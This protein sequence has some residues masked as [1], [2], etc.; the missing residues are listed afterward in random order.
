MK[1][2]L[3]FLILC[4][5]S[6]NVFAQDLPKLPKVNSLGSLNKLESLTKHPDPGAKKTKQWSFSINP[7]LWTVA[8][9]GTVGV[10]NTPSG[11]PKTFEFSKSFS[12]A[13]SSLKFAFM[14]GGRLKHKKVSFF[15][16]LSYANLKEFDI[17][18]PA[19]S[20]LTSAN[21]TNKELIID[22]SL[23]YE[24]YTGRSTFLDVYAGTR[25]WSLKSE[26]TLVPANQQPQIMLSSDKSWVDPIVGLNARFILGKKWFSY[27]RTD[28]GGFGVG[29]S[30]DFMLLG[31]FGYDLNPN[32]NTTLGVKYLG[33]DYD[34]DD[35]RWNVNHYGLLLSIGYRY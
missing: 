24:F 23:G 30:W 16:D 9:G 34:K 26:I 2:C 33:L 14:V 13:L 19:N 29:S 31:G 5:F 10:P 20:G 3:L 4:I 32:W 25:I 35:V 21:T 12:D 15:Y 27:L 28:F 22:L 18:L 11:Y 7:Y 1:K 8:I 6:S 17:T